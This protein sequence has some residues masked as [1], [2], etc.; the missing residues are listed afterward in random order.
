[1]SFIMTLYHNYY[2]SDCVMHWLFNVVVVFL[3]LRIYYR[4]AFRILIL[5]MIIV[6]ML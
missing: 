4:Q 6:I 1:M 3:F 5:Y 2:I